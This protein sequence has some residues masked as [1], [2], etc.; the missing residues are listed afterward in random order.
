[1]ISV[2]EKSRLSLALHNINHSRAT[3]LI[4]PF[5]SSPWQQQGRAQSW[6]TDVQRMSN[7]YKDLHI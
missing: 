6:L 3:R 2:K 5:V 4:V 1:M 7:I